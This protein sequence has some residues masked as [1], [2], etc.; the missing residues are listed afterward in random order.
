M[1]FGKVRFYGD[2]IELSGWHF[3]GRHRRCIPL[4][5]VSFLEY[6]TLHQGANLTLF[7]ENDRVISLHIREA[8]QWGE[9]FE[10]W[11]PCDIRSKSQ[12]FQKVDEVA[13]LV[14]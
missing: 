7:L 8:Y 6:H 12:A 11:M 14:G 3:R 4:A 9:L 1:Y 10:H 2:R 5:Q 13:T